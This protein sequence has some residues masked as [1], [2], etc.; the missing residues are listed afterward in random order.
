[1]SISLPLEGLPGQV[2]TGTHW[3]SPE[4]P[5]EVIPP[6]GADPPVPGAVP[7]GGPKIN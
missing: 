3:K 5:G 7:P 4:P 2:P 1:M 6:P